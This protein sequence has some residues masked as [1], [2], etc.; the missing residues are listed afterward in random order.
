MSLF[1]VKL[2][3]GQTGKNWAES[4]ALTENYTWRH[5][6]TR[7]PP[8]PLARI[9]PPRPHRPPSHASSPLEGG[10]HIRSPRDSLV[11]QVTEAN[12]T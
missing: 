9:V 10:Q 1:L 4:L 5:A 7:R 12:V 2:M 11:S 8:S 3:A 6:R